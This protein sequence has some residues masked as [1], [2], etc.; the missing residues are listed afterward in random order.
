MKS[1][2]KMFENFHIHLNHLIAEL[3]REKTRFVKTY[4]L[5]KWLDDEV[6]HQDQ[7]STKT[8]W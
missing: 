8:R 1:I 4:N 3:V 6:K 5:P 2:D 7:K